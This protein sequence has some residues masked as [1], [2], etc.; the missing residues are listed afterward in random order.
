MSKKKKQ[1]GALQKDFGIAMNKKYNYYRQNL[2]SEYH[3]RHNRRENWN[4]EDSSNIHTL[5][6]QKMRRRKH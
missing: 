3:I 2:K 5:E 1:Q 4:L 6:G